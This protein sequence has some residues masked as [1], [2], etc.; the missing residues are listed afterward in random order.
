MTQGP[1][2]VIRPISVSADWERIPQDYRVMSVYRRT[3][4]LVDKNGLSHTLI[5]DDED[6]SARTALI[7]CVPKVNIEDIINVSS[8]T[9]AAV[10]DPFL[11]VGQINDRWMPLIREWKDFLQDCDLKF[12]AEKWKSC[13]RISLVGL[14]PG[15][16]P[17]GD[18]F[19][20]GYL[21]AHVRCFLEEDNVVINFRKHYKAGSTVKLSENFYQDLFARKIWRRGK[22]LLE[23]LEGDDPVKVLDAVNSL[24]LWGHSSGLAW[25]AGFASGE[26]EIKAMDLDRTSF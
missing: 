17:A 6:F 12:I 10:Y 9:A 23:T 26:E 13:D 21:T 3:V 16:T 18:D 19:L 8:D 2:D 5:S 25:L 1:V 22:V 7:K 20:H 24:I 14:G 4:N 11:P 15:S